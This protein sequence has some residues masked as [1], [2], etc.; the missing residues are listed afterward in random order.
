MLKSIITL[1]KMQIKQYTIYKSNF[2]LWTLNRIIEV[3]VH[4]FVWQAI[5]NQTGNGYILYISSFNKFNCQLGN[6]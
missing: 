3:V 4:I 6:K 5:Y 1:A 2:Y